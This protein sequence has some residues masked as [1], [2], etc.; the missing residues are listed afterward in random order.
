MEKLSWLQVLSK[1]RSSK[2]FWSLKV[3]MC[4]KSYTRDQIRRKERKNELFSLY[5]CLA[6]FY[7]I[8]L[9]SCRLQFMNFYDFSKHYYTN[10]LLLVISLMVCLY[11]CYKHSFGISLII[12]DPSTLSFYPPFLR[13]V[14]IWA[15][16]K[17]INEVLEHTH[18]QTPFLTSHKVV[19]LL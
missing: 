8:L 3:K 19:H 9:F 15:W 5:T 1:R 4:I 17:I 12:P 6:F 10:E 16:K 18:S 13:Y 2:C 11:M 14:Y 7:M